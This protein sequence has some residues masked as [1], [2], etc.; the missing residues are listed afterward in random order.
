MQNPSALLPYDA[1][2]MGKAQQPMQIQIRDSRFE[3]LILKSDD[4]LNCR[5]AVLLRSAI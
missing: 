2:N 3:I 5:I 4:V 1:L